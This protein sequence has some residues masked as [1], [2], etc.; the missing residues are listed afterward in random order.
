MNDDPTREYAAAALAVGRA[1]GAEDVLERELGAVAHAMAGNDELRQVLTDQQLPVGRRLAAVDGDLLASAHPATRTVL[2]MAIAAERA[3]QLPELV[4][5][6]RELVASDRLDAEVVTAVALD[7]ERRA[8]LTR[9]LSQAT[10]H[11]LEVRFVVDPDVVGG[12]RATVGDTVIDG[13]LLRRM[14]QLRTRV[15]R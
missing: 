11:E 15:G 14:T 9:A 12:V 7:D 13:S 6:M 3:G 1:E 10:G 2:A 8:A 4:E 5:A